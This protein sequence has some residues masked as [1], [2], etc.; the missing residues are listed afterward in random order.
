MTSAGRFWTAPRTL[1]GPT[2]G[3]EPALVPELG[4]GRTWDENHNFGNTEGK[5]LGKVMLWIQLLR[6]LVVVYLLSWLQHLVPYPGL[7]Q[8]P[9]LPVFFLRFVASWCQLN[10]VQSSPNRTRSRCQ[11]LP[12]CWRNLKTSGRPDDY[13][14]KDLM[15]F[16]KISSWCVCCCG[17]LS[18]LLE[19]ILEKKN[20]LIIGVPAPVLFMVNLCVYLLFVL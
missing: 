13:M 1:W 18:E 12:L 16:L 14:R 17:M 20:E 9:Y 2:R 10:L 7:Q 6:S 15:L 11:N 4:Q 19:L 3:R 8:L 5:D